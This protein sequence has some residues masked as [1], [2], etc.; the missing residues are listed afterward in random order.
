MF[1]KLFLRKK[2]SLSSILTSPED[3]LLIMK[4]RAEEEDL[5]LV[6]F[7]TEGYD[8]Y[9]SSVGKRR[10]EEKVAIFISGILKV[11]PVITRCK[12]DTFALLFSGSAEE[13]KDLALS[14]AFSDCS[15]V[16]APDREVFS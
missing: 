13:T 11:A 2:N 4:K 9:V 5:S 8:D 1:K 6:C 14:I 10:V 7:K 15:V 3:F 12:R 16:V